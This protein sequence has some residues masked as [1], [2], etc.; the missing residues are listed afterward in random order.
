MTVNH[1]YGMALVMK[2][3][4]ARMKEEEEEEEEEKEEEE[5]AAAAAEE[6]F[7]RILMD[8]VKGTL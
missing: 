2:L 8:T 7:I 3:V 5:E 6:K 4:L 1:D